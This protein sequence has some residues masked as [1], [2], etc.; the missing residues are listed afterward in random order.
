VTATGSITTPEVLTEMLTRLGGLRS[1]TGRKWGT[2]TAGEMVCHLADCS[3]SILS[4]SQS[5]RP[6]KHRPIFKWLALYTSIPWPRGRKTPASVDPRRSGTRPG[7]F[8]SDRTR[9]VDSLRNFAVAPDAA[10]ATSHAVFGSMTPRDWRHWACRHT[11]Y[12][13][14]QFGL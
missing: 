12:H 5:K 8:E 13:L 9:A 7:D 4:G 1:D 6:V 10:F 11:D 3:A 14:K 2:M